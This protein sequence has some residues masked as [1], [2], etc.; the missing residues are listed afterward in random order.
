MNLWWD[1]ALWLMVLWLSALVFQVADVGTAWY[2]LRS[3]RTRSV[4]FSGRRAHEIFWVVPVA[5]LSALIPAFGVAVGAAMVIDRGWQL[6]AGV[7][8]SLAV[9]VLV[10]VALVI[11]IVRLLT[12]DVQGYATLRF[13]VREAKVR[14]VTKDE[15][16]RWRAELEAIDAREAVRHEDIARW[17]RLVP[18]VF[19]VLS[20]IA[21]WVAIAQEPPVAWLLVAVAALIP[22]VVSGI[23]AARGARL[24]LRARAAWGVVNGRQREQLVQAIETLERRA[25]R[26]VAGLSDRVNRALSIL[27]EQQL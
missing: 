5:A 14:K 21:V 22:A 24:S 10:S 13:T 4:Q 7:L 20:A 16:A 17:L 26:G 18:I 1:A 2:D 27:R 15:V 19:G 3:V 8:L 9:I 25:N 23:L 6:A 12:H 11:G